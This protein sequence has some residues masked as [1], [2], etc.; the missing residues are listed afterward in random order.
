MICITQGKVVAVDD[1]DFD[2]IIQWKWHAVKMPRKTGLPVWYARRSSEGTNNRTNILMHQEIARRAGWPSS[3]VIDHADRNGLNNTRGNLR[4]C[5]YSQNGANRRKSLGTYSRFKGVTWVKIRNKWKAMI[6][7][8]GMVSFLGEFENEEDAAK[9]YDAAAIKHFGS[10]AVTNFPT[11]SR[12]H[13]FDK[14]VS[15]V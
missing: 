10:Y 13:E 14:S 11:S 2:W 4:P 7:S 3:D 6:K 15:L 8:Y 5:S 1:Q 12:K 9:A